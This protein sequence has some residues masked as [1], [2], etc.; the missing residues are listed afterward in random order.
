M[1]IDID[2][3]ANWIASRFKLCERDI[4]CKDCNNQAWCNCE[5]PDDFKAYLLNGGLDEIQ[6]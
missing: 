5:T 2:K 4:S 3:L 1:D 6:L